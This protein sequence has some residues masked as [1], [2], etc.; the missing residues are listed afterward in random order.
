MNLLTVIKERNLTKLQLA[1]RSGINPNDLYQ[2]LNGKRPFYPKWKRLIA[3]YLQIGE[4][5]LFGG[6]SDEV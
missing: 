6:D 5:E 3:E 4:E 2:A 1:M